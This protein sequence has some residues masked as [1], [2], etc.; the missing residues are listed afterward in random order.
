[1]GVNKAGLTVAFYFLRISESIKVS[2]SVSM[3]MAGQSVTAGRSFCIA[4]PF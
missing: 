4:S 3:L 1:M 2:L